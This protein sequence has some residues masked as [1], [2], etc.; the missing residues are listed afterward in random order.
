MT[1][2]AYNFSFIQPSSKQILLPGAL[3][4]YVVEPSNHHP[5][6]KE[7]LGITKSAYKPFFLRLPPQLLSPPNNRSDYVD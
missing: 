6:Y 1:K 2:F 5:H 4:D 3:F 7:K